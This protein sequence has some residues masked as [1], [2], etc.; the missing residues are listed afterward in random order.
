MCPCGFRFNNARSRICVACDTVRSASKPAP[1]P[2]CVPVPVH[3]PV[4][5]LASP[6]TV[7]LAKGPAGFGLVIDDCC[8][9]SRAEREGVPIGSRITA[10]DG[11]AVETKEELLRKLQSCGPGVA[12]TFGAARPPSTPAPPPKPPSVLDRRG[13][14]N[15]QQAAIERGLAQ[16]GSVAGAEQIATQLRDVFLTIVREP[17]TVRLRRL[18]LHNGRV[19]AL[20]DTAGCVPI[21]E[22]TGF[23][24]TMYTEEGGGQRECMFLAPS[25]DYSA[26][27]TVSTATAQLLNDWLSQARGST[28]ATRDR[29][30]Q[31]DADEAESL[32]L[33]RQLRAEDE[34]QQEATER[35]RRDLLAAQGRDAF[36]QQERQ[37]R[38]GE[39]ASLALARQLQ[40][41]E[42][43]GGG[44]ASPSGGGTLT[45]GGGGAG[46]PVSASRGAG[47]GGNESPLSRQSSVRTVE[48]QQRD[49]EDALQKIASI[50]ASCA[51]MG[52][53]FVDPSFPP[54]AARCVPAAQCNCNVRT[55]V[56]LTLC[57]HHCILQYWGRRGRQARRRRG[58]TG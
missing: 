19:R 58:R 43:G 22:A 46:I 53:Q 39:E 20:L 37:E 21:L 38:E 47:G 54:C 25:K 17:D 7:I 27:V 24:R 1:A 8:H 49:F 30:Q 55:A 32:R 9:V 56:R 4:V 18:P 10:I 41:V 15:G 28:A 44:A 45:A 40:A 11:V 31:Q 2:A 33:A 5:D 50:N 6:L 36:L 29:Q 48:L 34:A 14:T 57:N 26:E 52:E 12:F 16:L 3:V 13:L 42:D 23:R 35:Q 51:A